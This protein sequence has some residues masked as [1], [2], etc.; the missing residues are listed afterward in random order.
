VEECHANIKA[1]DIDGKSVLFQTLS[2][3]NNLDVIKYLIRQRPSLMSEFNGKGHQFLHEACL[4]GK[5]EIVKHLV[6]NEGA[7]IESTDHFGHTCLHLASKFDHLEMVTFLV[8]EKGAN[9]VAKDVNGRTALHHACSKKSEYF[10]YMYD[11]K[12]GYF[13]NRVKSVG[14][15]QTN[16]QIADYLIGRGADLFAKDSEGNYPLDL[17]NNVN[18]PRMVHLLSSK[19]KRYLS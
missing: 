17:V 6:D 10:S 2:S 9:L 1:K 18:E 5:I 12:F 8:K 14:Q 16:V 13:E 7:D 11:D 15:E 4:R 3:Y 19:T